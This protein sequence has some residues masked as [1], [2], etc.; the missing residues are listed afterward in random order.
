MQIH[1]RFFATFREAVGQKELEW[2]MD[3]ETVTV[4]TVLE[5]LVN[6]YPDLEFFDESGNLREYLSILKN[7]RDITFLAQRE[8]ELTDGDVLSIFP[9]VAGGCQLVRE[10]TYRGISSRAARHYLT[11]MGG[12]A[13]DDTHIEAPKWRAELSETT[14]SVGPTLKLTEVTVRFEGA[15]HVLD[16]IIDTFSQKAM[17]A[18]G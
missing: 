13:R 15:E 17:R 2:E 14:V 18:G 6:T 11:G 9:P 5:E 8:T 1:L 16:D 10:R 7:G 3:A 4:G 12:E